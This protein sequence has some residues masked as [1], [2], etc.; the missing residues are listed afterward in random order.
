MELSLTS[1]LIGLQLHK[2]DSPRFQE[3]LSLSRK[4]SGRLRPS[5]QLQGNG[6][7]TRVRKPGLLDIGC[8]TG[9]MKEQKAEAEFEA[10]LKKIMS[11]NGLITVNGKQMRRSGNHEENKRIT[12]DLEVVLKSHDCPYIVKCLG[13]FISDADVWICMELMSTCFEKL[14]KKTQKPVPEQILGKVAVAT[15]KALNYLKEKHEVIHRDVK[16]SN[17]LL[18]EKGSI[19]LCDFGISGWL[20]DSK[21]KTRSAG[22]AAYMAPERIEP[23]DPSHPNYD[24]RADV[25]ALGITLVELATG[26]FPYKDCT[27]DFELLARVLKDDPPAITQEDGFSNEFC[28]FIQVCLI[29]NYKQRPK[30]KKLL[31]HPFIRRYEHADVDVTGWYQQVLASDQDSTF[32]RTSSKRGSSRFT[33]PS[34]ILRRVISDPPPIPP[35][36]PDSQRKPLIQRLT[37]NEALAEHLGLF[38]G[39]SVVQIG[40]GGLTLHDMNATQRSKRNSEERLPDMSPNCGRRL[41]QESRYDES[42]LYPTPQESRR[43]FENLT[44]VRGD[45]SPGAINR[46]VLFHSRSTSSELVGFSPQRR[47]SNSS[48]S[49]YNQQSPS[50]GS[51][52][53]EFDSLRTWSLS[54]PFQNPDNASAKKSPADKSTQL[55][56]SLKSLSSRPPVPDI[57][58]RPPSREFYKLGN[59]EVKKTSYPEAVGTRQTQETSSVRC[60]VKDG[61][62]G[63]APQYSRRISVDSPALPRRFQLPPNTGTHSQSATASRRHGSYSVPASPLLPSRNSRGES[64]ETPPPLPPRHHLTPEPPRGFYGNF[65]YF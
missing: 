14:L 3:E 10:R 60:F 12:M 41:S 36:T 44:S 42:E 30:Y 19:K 61:G 24:I 8:G 23:P 52:T 55:N 65:G 21:A 53:S 7:P 54:T 5:L 46:P 39:K 33:P 4:N 32:K 18:D 50:E 59:V 47:P 45:S 51:P 63:N 6:T 26:Q 2:N 35:R 27:T 62:H 49:S 43:K 29:K 38:N 25:W 11:V 58:P 57:Q 22:C 28:S 16:P 13:C 20:E 34:P 9:P 37:S 15:I 31:E 48:I 1:K 64:H 17:I 40:S 56:L